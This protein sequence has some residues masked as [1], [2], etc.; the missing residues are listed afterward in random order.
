MHSDRWGGA[1]SER[2]GG[3]WG[4]RLVRNLRNL[5]TLPPPVDPVTDPPPLTGE[6]PVETRPLNVGSLSL[7]VLMVL[8]EI[9]LFVGIGDAVLHGWGPEVPGG[10]ARWPVWCLFTLLF[11][12]ATWLYG[13][14][15]FHG[16]TVLTTTEV[17]DRD[18]LEGGRRL[19]VADVRAIT[20]NATASGRELV[21]VGGRRTRFTFKEADEAWDGVIA[22]LRAWV[23]TRPELATDEKLRRLLT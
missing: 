7:L 5:T 4:N 19:L 17:R 23:R 20:V 22:N 11:G 9:G 2:L 15:L 14:W 13:W 1:L 21:I 12:A 3:R 10:W 18:W 6:S 8:F 16:G